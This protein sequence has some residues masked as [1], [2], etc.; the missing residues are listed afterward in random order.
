MKILGADVTLAGK[1][2]CDTFGD[3]IESIVAGYDAA[4]GLIRSSSDSTSYSVVLAI[5]GIDRIFLH[6]PGANDTFC[7]DDLPMEAIKK[8]SVFHFGYPPLMKKIYENSGSELARIMR[9]VQEAGAATS[10]DLCTP[11]RDSEAGRSDWERILSGALTY[12]DVFAPSAEEIMFMLKRDRYDELRKENP[13]KDLTEVMDIEQDIRPLAKKCLDMGAKIVLIKC[14]KMGMFY[15]TKDRSAIEKISP[16]LELNP[17]VWAD[18]TGFEKSFRPEKVLSGTGAG[19]TS[20]AAFLTAMLKGYGIEDCVRYAAATGA[21]CVEAYDALG[22]LKSFD[23]IDRK[24][25]LG[26]EKN[27]E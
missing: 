14:G 3:M 8:A 26:W 2:G 5:P 23:E 9:I 21:C 27:L 12:V 19:D 13:G 1:I 15:C 10:L 6:D 22:G 17:A 25:A 4:A 11:D 24:I 20:V 7:A 16:K 18:K